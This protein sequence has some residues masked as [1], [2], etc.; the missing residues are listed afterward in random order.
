MTNIITNED[1]MT[2][3][4]EGIRFSSKKEEKRYLE[5]KALHEKGEI[6]FYLKQEPVH[7]DPLI[8]IY[9]N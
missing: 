3:E 5:L 4:N 8:V 2:L 1:A 6:I 7:V 9:E